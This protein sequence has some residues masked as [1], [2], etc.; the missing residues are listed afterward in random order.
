VDWQIIITT[1]SAT[2]FATAAFVYLAKALSK[3]LL[4]LDLE[5]FKGELKA[6]H[7]KELE[8]L[9]ADLRIAA[10]RQETTF[11]K[12]HEKR[13][14][15]IAELYAKLAAVNGA[16]HE[17]LSPLELDGGA[18]RDKR[19]KSAAEAGTNFARYYRSHQIYFDESLCNLLDSFSRDMIRAWVT[20]IHN[21]LTGEGGIDRWEPRLKEWERLDKQVPT[22][23]K[24]IEQN[25]RQL[26]GLSPP[27][28]A[29]SNS[30]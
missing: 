29:S 27:N 13:A 2:G 12:L 9:R 16:M 26:L 19:E 22:V 11:A 8:R 7:E 5:R 18:G 4:S 14:E 1:L 21:P 25:F 17:L 24:E 23:R 6:T 28:P 3:H 15:V 20:H 30:K 10:F